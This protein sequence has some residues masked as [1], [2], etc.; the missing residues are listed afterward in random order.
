MAGFTRM[1]DCHKLGVV[2][3]M[4]KTFIRFLQVGEQDLTLGIKFRARVVLDIAE[5]TDGLRPELIDDS[6][7][8]GLR[9]PDPTPLVTG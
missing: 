4:I 1:V 9:H 3:I 5:H 2:H 8:G 7:V 6:Q